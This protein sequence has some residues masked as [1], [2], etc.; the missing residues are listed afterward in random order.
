ME[1]TYFYKLFSSN[2]NS[3]LSFSFSI[4]TL[5]F[6]F[7]KQVSS[8]IIYKDFLIK[9]QSFILHPSHSFSPFLKS[10]LPSFISLLLS[11]TKAMIS[12]CKNN[13]IARQNIYNY[14]E[15]SILFRTRRYGYHNKVKINNL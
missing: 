6:C 9:Y 12:G 14:H 4:S 13:A 8:Y 15:K 1:L 3:L 5:L 10:I 2:S 11:P 7:H